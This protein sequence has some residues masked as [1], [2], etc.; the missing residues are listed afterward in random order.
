MPQERA[1]DAAYTRHRK[2]LPHGGN[3]VDVKNF[4]FV[5]IAAENQ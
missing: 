3:L 4:A 2:N 1:L 5:D